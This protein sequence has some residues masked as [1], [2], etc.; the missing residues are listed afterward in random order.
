[1]SSDIAA[2]SPS[3]PARY[4]R[5]HRVRITLWIAAAEGVLTLFHAIPHLAVYA[6]AVV[7]I[8]FWAATGRTY[9]SLTARQASWIF[10]ASQALAVLVPVVWFV[11]RAVA[12]GVIV[13][14]AIGALI[15]LFLDRERS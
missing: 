5:R 10:A 13:V 14:L 1:M 4:L 9:R 15:F 2:S 6:L 8:A 12:I 3:A 11:A 7:A